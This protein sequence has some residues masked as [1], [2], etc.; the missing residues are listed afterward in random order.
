MTLPV[1]P[2]PKKG[3]RIMADRKPINFELVEEWEDKKAKVPGE[4]YA[5]LADA[6]ERWHPH[7]SEAR[8]VLAWR[9]N[10]TSDRDGNL[11]LGKCQKASDLHR[12]L[13]PYDFVILLNQEAW[14]ELTPAQR[15]A[16]VDHELC[17]AQVTQG[18]DGRPKRDEVGRPV[19]RVR[20]HDIEEF[21]EIASRHGCYKADLE[22]FV[23]AALASKDV[24]PFAGGEAESA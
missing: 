20:R 6:R 21:R 19:F 3:T 16:L 1:T 7:L 2:E 24:L 4:P 17:H 18:E 15:L 10:W 8:I 13:A 12:W 14:P 11:V 5:L 9:K 22:A 23:R